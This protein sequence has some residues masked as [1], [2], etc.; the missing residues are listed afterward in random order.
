MPQLLNVCRAARLVGVTRV[1][2]QKKIKD[3]N[4]ASFDGMVVAED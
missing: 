3:G 4:L 2:L 1:A